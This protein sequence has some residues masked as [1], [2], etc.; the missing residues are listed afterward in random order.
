MVE[1]QRLAAARIPTEVS[2]L[3]KAFSPFDG[4]DSREWCN[5]WFTGCRFARS[6]RVVLLDVPRERKFAL[7]CFGDLVPGG[8]PVFR[9]NVPIG[10]SQ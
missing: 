9:G 10:P 3:R 4:G 8:H 6:D 1:P 2:I 5:E 7:A